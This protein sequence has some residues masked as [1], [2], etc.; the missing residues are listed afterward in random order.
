MIAVE[1][2]DKNMRNT[3][4]PDLVV[5]HLYLRSFPA[6]HQKAKAIQCYYLAGWMPVK[7]RYGGVISKDGYSEHV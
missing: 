7:C 1:M 5:D 2:R 3:A 4:A 6:I